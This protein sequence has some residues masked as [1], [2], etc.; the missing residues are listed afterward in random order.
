MIINSFDCDGVITLGLYPGPDDVIITGRSFE[1]EGVTKKYLENKNIKN[2]VFFSPHK[3][4]DKT[5]IK[6]GI[7]K[8]NTIL[9]LY[10]MGIKINIHF[11]DDIEQIN[12]I[13]KIIKQ[14]NL[15][16]NIV[17]VNHNGLE[18]L[19]NV[20]RDEFGNIIK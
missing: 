6:S 20:E 1:E 15:K 17:Y 19:E 8:G 11:D 4:K 9:F 14:H 13:Q 3:F 18:E 2:K 5:R 12:E 16:T 10:K 7:H